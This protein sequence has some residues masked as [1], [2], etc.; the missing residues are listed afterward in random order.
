MEKGRIHMVSVLGIA[1]AIALL[2][3]LAFKQWNMLLVSLLCAVIVGLTSGI[4][5]WAVFSDYYMPGLVGFFG[6]WF[7]IFTIGA[8]Y[9]EFMS[10]SGSVSA[11]AYKLV[12]VFGKDK[13]LLVMFIVC[14]LLNLGGV[15][16]YVQIF[17]VWPMAV[18]LS[19]EFNIHRGIWLSVFYLGLFT[20]QLFPGNPSMVNTVVSQ[21][22]QVSAGTVPLVCLVM[23]LLYAAAG[24]LI[25]RRTEKRWEAKGRR[26]VETE[27]DRQMVRPERDN[28][29]GLAVALIP[30]ILVIF[31]YT[32]LTSGWF[33]FV[34]IKRLEASNSILASM[35][36]ACIACYL[37]NL[38]TLRGREKDIIFKGMAGGLNPTF[39]AAV[40]AGFLGVITGSQGYQLFTEA[41]QKVGGNPYMQCLIAGSVTGFIT[42]GG[43]VTAQTVL[44]TFGQGWLANPSVNPGLLRQITV[45]NTAGGITLSPHSGG[46]HGVMG[47]AGTDLK[48]SYPV[49]ITS[50]ILPSVVINII[51]SAI[52]VFM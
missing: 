35:G 28:L 10:R 46:L 22:L 50:V 31:L 7:L 51:F 42:G 5:L 1:A 3:F 8:V 17:I 24:Y 45:A 44:G 52:A 11:I 9:S 15:N 39:A 47:F 30:M 40:I 16:P 41:V 2:V 12:D 21:I 49:C 38:K 29:P 6:S 4:G 27:S 34:G 33:A 26:Y 25:I 43:A 23:F 32:G 36:V 48:E 20:A 37:L 19:K 14:C 18:V 13:I